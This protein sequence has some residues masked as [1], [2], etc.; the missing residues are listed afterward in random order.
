MLLVAAALVGLL[1]LRM[2]YAP[3]ACFGY[4]HFSRQQPLTD[5]QEM[6]YQAQ[7]WTLEE[8]VFARASLARA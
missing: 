2:Y 1:F 5:P 8:L 6:V 3:Q 7:L 4:G